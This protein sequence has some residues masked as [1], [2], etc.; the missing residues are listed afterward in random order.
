M[1]ALGLFAASGIF[2]FLY[3]RWGAKRTWLFSII[4]AVVLPL[5]LLALFRWLLYVS[6]PVG[7][8]TGW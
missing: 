5:L 1:L 3:L 2:A 7:M 8:L 6:T 4:Y